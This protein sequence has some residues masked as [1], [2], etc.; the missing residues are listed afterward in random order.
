M[1]TKITHRVDGANLVVMI[2]GS[3]VAQG[4]T[5]LKKYVEPFLASDD[6][7]H[8][9]MNMK[10]VNFIDSSGVGFMISVFKRL[11]GRN[12]KF[13]LCELSSKNQDIFRLTRLDKFLSIYPSVEAA[14]ANA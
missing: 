11:K 9:I 12:A 13:A 8:L 3:L 4:V 14:I 10:G 5:D 1:I 7:K 2:E 6:V